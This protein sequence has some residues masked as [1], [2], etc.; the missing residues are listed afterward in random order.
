MV[1]DSHVVRKNFSLDSVYSIGN[2]ITTW[3]NE[4]N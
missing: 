2:F 1:K 4:A 3:V